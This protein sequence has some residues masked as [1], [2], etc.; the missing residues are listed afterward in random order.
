MNNNESNSTSLYEIKGEP[1]FNAISEEDFHERVRKVFNILERILSRSFG[2][3]GS[4]TIISNLAKSTATKDGYTIARNLVADIKEGDPVDQAILNLALVIC[5]RLNYK[6]GD[7]TTTAIIAANSVYDEYNKCLDVIK[8]LNLTPRDLLARMK[9][10]Q[11]RIVDEIKKTAI[12]M[13]DDDSLVDNIRKIV[14]ISSNDNEEITNMITEAYKKVGAPFITSKLSPDMITRLSIIEGYSI[15]VALTDEIY[16]NTDDYRCVLDNVDVLIFDYKINDVIYNNIIAPLNSICKRC[17]R[18][19]VIIAPSYDQTTLYRNIRRDIQKEYDAT[20]VVNLVI[21]I[22]T[23]TTQFTK[24][25]LG[26]LAILLNTQIIDKFVLDNILSTLSTK[27]NDTEKNIG[28]DDIL[29][30]HNRNI[31]GITI[32]Y[33]NGLFGEY[34]G[35]NNKS[36]EDFCLR[37]GFAGHMESGPKT[38]SFSGFNYNKG[39]YVKVCSEAYKEMTDAIETYSK[40]GSYSNRV[41]EA[42]ERYNSLKLKMA[43]IEVGGDSDLSQNTFKDALDDSIRAAESA[44]DHGYILGC[45]L[46]TI[47]IIKKMAVASDDIVDSTLLSILYGGFCSVYGRVITNAY[48]DLNVAFL[49]HELS[50]DVSSAEIASYITTTIEDAIGQH[51]IFDPA[52]IEEIF[53]TFLD[54]PHIVEQV[55]DFKKTYATDPEKSKL[56]YE[57]N[58]KVPLSH[59]I[60]P[61]SVAIGQVFD[62]SEKNFSREIINSADTDIQVVTAVMD[63]VSILISGNQ[64]VLTSKNTYKN[65]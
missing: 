58:V 15:N 51:N 22:A 56:L 27:S 43:S 26:D 31:E 57:L 3:Y 63:L 25:L 41:V 47:S 14:K 64:M 35:K 45:N 40:L 46:T 50:K 33:P 12:P 5:A 61:Y 17:G 62:L 39:L 60:I 9:N 36:E 13:R 42:Q 34:D 49:G 7:G 65:L 37:V 18:K 24:K 29:N 28:I 2:P 19:L 52:I 1:K 20:S 59:I 11:D 23:A 48:G 38:T 30:I 16:I 54:V 10:I 8:R 4:A 6:V 53:P 55:N 21:L 32:K 44:Y